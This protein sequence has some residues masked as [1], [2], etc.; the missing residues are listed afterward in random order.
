[1]SWRAERAALNHRIEQWRHDWE[2]RDTARFLRHYAPDFRSDE[3]RL[4]G[5]RTLK[6]RIN[7]SKDW[8][9][10]SLHNLSMF[11]SPGKEEIVV[12]TFEQRY[13][14]NNLNS[15]LKKRQY[16]TKRGGQW[17][18]AYEGPA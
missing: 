18:I 1:M 6:T 17:Q 10:I 3:H 15:D 2:S 14:S 11:R 7:S 4:E 12:V 8:V 13:R 16:W 5:W 9:K